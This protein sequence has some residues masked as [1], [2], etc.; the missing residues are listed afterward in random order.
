M[1]YG[2]IKDAGYDIYASNVSVRADKLAEFSPCLEKLVPIIQQAGVDYITSP[3]ATNKV[4]V[5]VVSQDQT[6]SPYSEGEAAFSADLL[7]EKG[8]LANEDNGAFG[9]YD[10]AR[11]SRNVAELTPVLAAG[12]NSVPG[13]MTAQQMFT[14]Q[15]TDP[16]ISIP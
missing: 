7:Q 16:A 13:S 10:D 2:L 5:D 3:E 11:T 1:S 14:N 15:F 6:Y 12:G 8:L 4:I 9:V